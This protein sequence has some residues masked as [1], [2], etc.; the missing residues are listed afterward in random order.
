MPGPS[1]P[2]PIPKR[3]GQDKRSEPT[4]R[5]DRTAFAD[6]AYHPTMSYANDS[7]YNAYG[8]LGNSPYTR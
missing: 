7:V 8:G 3:Y 5:V 2:K 6:P 4:R 1:G